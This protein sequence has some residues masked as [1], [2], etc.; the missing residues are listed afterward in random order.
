MEN[1]TLNSPDNILSIGQGKLKTYGIGGKRY[2]KRSELD[3]LI[4]EIK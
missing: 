4:Q 2:Y 3:S 1:N